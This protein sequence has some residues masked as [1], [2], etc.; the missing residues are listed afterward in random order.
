MR[1][2]V[3]ACAGGVNAVGDAFRYIRDG[4]AEVMVCGGAEAAVTPMGVGGFTSMKALCLC[5][6]PG[7]GLHSL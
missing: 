5:H 1:L 6:G 7:P 4:Y 3:A 2:P